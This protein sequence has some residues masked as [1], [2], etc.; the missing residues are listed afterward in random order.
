M[1]F[2]T[3]LDTVMLL[4]R[5]VILAHKHMVHVFRFKTH[6]D[7]ISDTSSVY[8]HFLLNR[9]AKPFE[10]HETVAQ[11]PK[12]SVVIIILCSTPRQSMTYYVSKDEL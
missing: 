8:Q 6:D 9:N 5:H 4:H 3:A 1:E 11:C 7:M 2:K 10:E 12:N